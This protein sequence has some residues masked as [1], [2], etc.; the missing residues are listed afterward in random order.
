[1]LKLVFVSK[2]LAFC[3]DLEGV[4]DRVPS[5]LEFCCFIFLCLLISKKVLVQFLFYV[6]RSPLLCILSEVIQRDKSLFWDF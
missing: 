4:P 3:F 6:M 2:L 5:P 1:M